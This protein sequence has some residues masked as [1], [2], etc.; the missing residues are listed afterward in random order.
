MVLFLKGYSYVA[1]SILFTDNRI[2]QDVIYNATDQPQ[3]IE[4][5]IAAHFKVCI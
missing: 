3:N 4:I 5:D 2:T 1:P